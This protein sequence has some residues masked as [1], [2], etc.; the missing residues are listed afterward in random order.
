MP[1]SCYFILLK[2]SFYVSLIIQQMLA[3]YKKHLLLSIYRE[4]L[5]G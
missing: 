4:H 2:H 1:V 5:S 3:T